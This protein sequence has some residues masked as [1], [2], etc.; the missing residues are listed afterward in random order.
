MQIMTTPNVSTTG[1]IEPKPATVPT[2]HFKGE[3]SL[4]TAYALAEQL[5]RLDTEEVTYIGVYLLRPI[6]RKG[7]TSTTELPRIWVS[8]YKGSLPGLCTTA[9]WIFPI[10][11]DGTLGGAQIVW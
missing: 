5:E 10:N 11:S 7:E 6:P 4:K 2:W 9:K 3:L 1:E 8:V